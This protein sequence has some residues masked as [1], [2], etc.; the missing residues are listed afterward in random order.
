[1]STPT[2]SNFNVSN[3]S[4]RTRE[5]AR[6]VFASTLSPA[7]TFL[8][9]KRKR[10]A[11]ITGIS[12]GIAATPYSDRNTSSTNQTEAVQLFQSPVIGTP[13]ISIQLSPEATQ[14]ICRDVEQKVR[15]KYANLEKY[16][17]IYGSS[18]EKAR[19]R[20]LSKLKNE[21]GRAMKDAATATNVAARK[22]AEI[23][24]QIFINGNIAKANAKKRRAQLRKNKITMKVVELEREAKRL[25]LA[26]Q[27]DTIRNAPC[28]LSQNR[29]L[30]DS[31]FNDFPA[32]DDDGDDDDGEDLDATAEADEM[33]SDNEE[34][35]AEDLEFIVQDED[36]EQEYQD[37]DEEYEEED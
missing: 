19:I 7:T 34:P 29:L 25:K 1:M 33:E 4:T 10:F 18:A 22:A 17:K 9:P 15:F 16:G 2:E 5:V 6:D 20:H 21:H 30:T 31:S 12:P 36:D 37:D 14:K 27:L 8:T 28:S 32:D 13:D 26:E 35:T 24:A 3:E 23:Q 11:S